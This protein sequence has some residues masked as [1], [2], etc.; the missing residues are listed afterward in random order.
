MAIDFPNSPS[1]GDSFITGTV[2]YTWNG[3]SWVSTLLLKTAVSFYNIDA[4]QGGDYVLVYKMPVTATLDD[5]DHKLDVGNL[6]LD[7]KKNSNTINGF[8]NVVV[9][10]M[11]QTNV[12]M[13]AANTDN[14][15]IVD[16]ELMITVTN[17]SAN[18]A[19]MRLSV[20]FT[21]G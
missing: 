15:F 17:P 12:H 21:K 16:D 2:K 8:S 11:S 14:I 9:N 3:T 6:T 4:A 13:G 7:V 10:T 1:P 18:A 20:N 5:I 19:N